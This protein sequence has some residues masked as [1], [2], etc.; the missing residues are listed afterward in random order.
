MDHKTKQELNAL[1]KE[2]FGTASKWKKLIDNGFVHVEQGQREV[3][4]PDLETRS[5][6][7]KTY[8]TSTPVLVRYTVETVRA[9]MENV[10]KDRTE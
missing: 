2:V 6:K 1:S 7:K 4:V 8:A 10:L 5:F 3:V 9:M